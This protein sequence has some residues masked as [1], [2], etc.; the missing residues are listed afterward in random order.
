M[1]TY[2]LD[3]T[4]TLSANKPEPNNYDIKDG[5]SFEMLL[6]GSVQDALIAQMVVPDPYY[7]DNELET[8]FIGRSDWNISR[9]F[10]MKRLNAKAHCILKLEKVDTIATLFINDMEVERFDK[11]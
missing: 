4:W 8:M 2:I 11:G 7:A 9:T 5:S 6:P 10:E 3:G 1:R